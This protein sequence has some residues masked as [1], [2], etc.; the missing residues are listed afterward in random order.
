MASETISVQVQY[1][2]WQTLYE[3]EAPFLRLFKPTPGAEDD[4][5]TNLAFETKSVNV[6]DIRGLQTAPTLDSHGFRI[7]DCATQVTDFSN[8]VSV[9]E[10]Y[11]AECE[12]LLRTTVEGADEVLCFDWRV[13]DSA[14]MQR[15]TQIIET[16]SNPT[17]SVSGGMR[18]EDVERARAYDPENRAAMLSPAL[19]V[20]IVVSRIKHHFK[21]KS[22]QLLRGRFRVI[23]WPLAV[24]DGSTLAESDVIEAEHRRETFS[25]TSLYCLPRKSHRW[26]FQSRHRPDE[27]LLVKIYDSNTEVKARYCPHTS[28]KLPNV[29]PDAPSRKSIEVRALVLSYPKEQ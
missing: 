19:L 12:K 18:D 3:T 13:R 23:N 20:H 7:A 16:S 25:E 5:A 17:S 26:Y 9:N 21:E 6:Q 4:R 8:P 24:C 10:N 14:T 15:G 27:A 1:L 22:D 2:Q 29:H 11:L 28:F